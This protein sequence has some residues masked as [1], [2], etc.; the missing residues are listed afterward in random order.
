MA[1]AAVVEALD[2]LEDRVRKL[3]AGIPGTL[4]V[5]GDSHLYIERVHENQWS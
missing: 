4:L 2:V 3:D 1:P 5:T